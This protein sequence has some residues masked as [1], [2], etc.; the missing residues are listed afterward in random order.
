M[1]KILPSSAGG[2]GSVPDGELRSHMPVSQKKN[3]NLKLNQYCNKCNKDVKMVHIK[4]RNLSGNALL[5]LPSSTDL[6]AG[7]DLPHPA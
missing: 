7:F 2:A 1:A 6:L 5:P 4:K 3:Q